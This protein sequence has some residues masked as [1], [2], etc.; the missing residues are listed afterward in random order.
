MALFKLIM[1]PEDLP[2]V[3]SAREILALDFKRDLYDLAKP[4]EMAKDVAAF[5]NAS[6]GSILV[7][8]DEDQARHVLASYKPISGEAIAAAQRGAVSGAVRD[9]CGPP[10]F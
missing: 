2:P 1:R 7:G 9:R 10:A 5:A 6:G 8:A 3:G 4:F